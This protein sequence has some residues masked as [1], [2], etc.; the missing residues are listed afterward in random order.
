MELLIGAVLGV[1]VGA[2]APFAVT[3]ARKR[4]PRRAPTQ[5]Q[6]TNEYDKRI[7]TLTPMGLERYQIH[8][9]NLS[10]EKRAQLRRDLYEKA[11]PVL[12]WK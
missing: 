8:M 6:R 4:R 7:D 3:K 12:G 9:A 5:V 10:T 1:V 2:F 11:A